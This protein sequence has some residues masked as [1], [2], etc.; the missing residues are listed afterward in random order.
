[1]TGERDK[2]AWTDLHEQLRQILN[3]VLR[4]YAG[5][6]FDLLSATEPADRNFGLSAITNRREKSLL[7]DGPRDFVVF[8]LVPE[9]PGHP[10]TSAVDFTRPITEG[11][12]QDGDGVAGPDDRFLMAMCMVQQR[13]VGPP[14]AKRIALLVQHAT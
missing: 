9:R 10:A 5:V 6:M 14:K 2:H 1:M 11:R 13:T 7:T 4:T 12:P 8:D 3:D